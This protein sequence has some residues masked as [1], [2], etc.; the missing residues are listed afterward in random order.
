ME[1]KP[2]GVTACVVEP[3]DTKTGFTDRREYT[4]QTAHTAY[5]WPFERATYEMIRSELAS[6]GPEHCAR[7]VLKMAKRARPPIR[8][9]IRLKYKIFYMLTRLAP[10]SLKER[11]TELVYLKKDPPAG[12]VWTYDKQFKEKK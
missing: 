11:M 9:S 1:L 5:R 12:G 7:V 2:F 10:L 8:R 4:K 3:G 6:P